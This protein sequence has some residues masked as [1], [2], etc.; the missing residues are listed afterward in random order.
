VIVMEDISAVD[1]ERFLTIL[2]SKCEHTLSSMYVSL[3]LFKLQVL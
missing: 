3:T 2:Y 1:L